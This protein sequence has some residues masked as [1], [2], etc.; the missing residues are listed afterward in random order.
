[1]IFKKIPDMDLKQIADSGQVFRM[2][3][4]NDSETA[5]F[6][7]EEHFHG[8]APCYK[9]FTGVYSV[10][11]TQNG[12]DF[13]FNCDEDEFD[14]VWYK[15]FDLDTDY[16]EIKAKCDRADAYLSESIKKGFGIRILNQD[17]WEVIISF[18]ISQNNNIKRIRGSIERLCEMTGNGAFPDPEFLSEIP[19]N[20]LHSLGLGYRDE[21]VHKMAVAVMEGTFEPGRLRGMSYEEARAELMKQYGIGKKVAD[22]ICI[23]GLHKLEAFPIDTHV[24]Q[25]LAEHYP[26]G[27]PFDKYEGCAGVMQQYMFYNE[28]NK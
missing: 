13:A 21:Y 5:M 27:F 20:V 9:A 26:D 11:I 16:G 6:K 1:M 19:V 28:L 25:I 4:A 2:V 3:P 24:K 23:F 10:V 12:S 8:N 22:C 14:R 7:N 18:I 15:Y 17:L